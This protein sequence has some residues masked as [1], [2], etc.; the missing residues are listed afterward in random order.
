ME[1]S[2]FLVSLFQLDS[3][4]INEINKIGGGLKSPPPIF[5]YFIKPIEYRF[6]RN[7]KVIYRSTSK[8]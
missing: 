7:H 5:I 6:L 1:K 3:E 2:T 8:Q 4:Y